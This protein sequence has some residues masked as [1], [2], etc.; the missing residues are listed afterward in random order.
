MRWIFLLLAALNIFYFVWTRQQ[1]VSL[2]D[3]VAPFALSEG[4]RKDIRLISEQGRAAA[5][6]GSGRTEEGLC[7]HLG[8]F[9]SEERASLLAQRL[10]SL[11]IPVQQTAI[12]AEFAKD[13]WVY[14]PPFGSRDA[15]LRQFRELQA[16]G[17]DSFLVAEG[18]LAN[19]ISLGIFSVQ[20]LAVGLLERMRGQGYGAEMRELVRERREYWVR[21]PGQ[22]VGLLGDELLGTLARDFLELRRQMLSCAGALATR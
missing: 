18:D 20:G 8:G 21:V 9:E 12:S 16:R 1:P 2:A 22:A 7:L 11:D 14:L 5:A 3:G 6:Q 4:A 10:L 19:G 13:Y 15:A 17:I